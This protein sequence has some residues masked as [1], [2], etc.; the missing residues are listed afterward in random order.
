AAAEPGWDPE[1][2]PESVKTGRTNDEVAAG[3]KAP[4]KRTAGKPPAGEA[5]AAKDAPEKTPARRAAGGR[6]KKPPAW[7]PAAADELA[8]LDALPAKGDWEFQGRTLRLTNLDKVLF[9]A[10]AGE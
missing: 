9:P 2:H 3:A 1:Q 7:E 10:R 4:T 5:K 6:P 8:A